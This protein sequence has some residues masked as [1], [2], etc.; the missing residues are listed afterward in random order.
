MIT[1]TANSPVYAGYAVSICLTVDERVELTDWTNY[2]SVANCIGIA[3]ND[4][5]EGT[6]INVQTDGIYEN[7]TWTFTRCQPVYVYAMGTLTQQQLP[8]NVL[9][10]GRAISATKIIIGISEF[11]M[12]SQ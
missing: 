8:K 3:T 6:P 4:G 1:L 9:Q 10:I 5:N 2:Q 7:L 12:V 11:I